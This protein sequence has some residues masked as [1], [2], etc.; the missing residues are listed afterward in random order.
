MR[1]SPSEHNPFDW[2][3]ALGARFARAVVDAVE[4]LE[5][6]RDSIG[7]AV[8]AQGAA[9]MAQG[10]AKHRFDRTI[11]TGDLRGGQLVGNGQ[12]MD[13]GGEERFVGVDVSQAGNDR[14]IEQRVFDRTSGA[15]KLAA[16]LAGR[17]VQWL[18]THLVIGRVVLS[19]PPNAAEAARVGEAHLVTRAAELKDQ[20]S[21][22]LQGLVWP[23][24]AESAGHA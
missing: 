1:R 5:L 19:Q 6:P 23:V 11:E 21:M 24:Q 13:A 2:R 3:S 7:I 22:E 16:E 10:A 14:L 12:R 17:Q 18:G 15:G 9:A 4:F 20:V 8:I